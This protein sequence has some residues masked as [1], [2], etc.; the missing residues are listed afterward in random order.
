MKNAAVFL[1]H[2]VIHDWPD[3][4]CIKILRHLRD[5]ATPETRLLIVDNL[6]SYACAEE[7]IEDIPGAN[8][9]P[10]P[11]AP[12]LPNYGAAGIANYY[13]DIAMLAL[14]NGKERTLTEVNVLLKETGWKLVRVVRSM[15]IST[16]KAIAVPA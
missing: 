14:Q 16:Q 2:M 6:M 3:Q 13:E 15:Q 8:T 11:P 12:L 5:A 4:Y 9:V 7:G 1:L 10:P